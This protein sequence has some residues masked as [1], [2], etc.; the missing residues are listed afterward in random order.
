MIPRAMDSLDVIERVMLAEE[1]FEA[2]I[3]NNDAEYFSLEEIVDWLES[4]LSNQRPSKQAARLLGK[5]ARISNGPNWLILSMVRGG[6][7]KSQPSFERSSDS[8]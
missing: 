3:P 2:N 8:H 6:E 5:L 7:S 4:R 1:I